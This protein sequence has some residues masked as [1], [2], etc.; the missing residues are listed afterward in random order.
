VEL[1]HERSV[2]PLFVSGMLLLVLIF[3]SYGVGHLMYSDQSSLN[4]F[5]WSMERAAGLTAYG[6]LT[7]TVAL[8]MVTRSG[9]W[10]KWRLRSAMSHVHQFVALLFI[11]FVALHLWGLFQDRSVPF[12][13]VQALVP[14][15]S[16]YRPIPVGFGILSMYG[17]F[18]L[19]V[20]SAL[21]KYIGA[22]AW[23]ALHALSFP[24]FIMVT[25]HGLF[26]GT[27]STQVWGW[28][29]YAAGGGIFLLA[30]VT[31]LA[32]GKRHTV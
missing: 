11:P 29:V 19:I 32:Q 10:D 15:Q 8:G 4:Q 13:W 21:R 25:L 20:S 5:F 26:A 6:L 31:R 12:S 3:G 1:V 27:D 17:M 7:T 16:T 28:S 2:T 9:M 30:L 18:V 22:R 14:L 24:L 23:R